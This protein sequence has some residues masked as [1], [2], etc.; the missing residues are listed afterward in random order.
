MTDLC[1]I[2]KI[3]VY[4]IAGGPIENIT[5]MSHYVSD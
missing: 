2:G 1:E 5:A 4:S 3:S